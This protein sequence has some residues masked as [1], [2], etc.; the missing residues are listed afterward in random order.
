MKNINQRDFIWVLPLSIGLGAVLSYLQSGNWLIGWLGFSLLFL[1]CFSLLTL[2]IRWAGGGKTLA[3]MVA[4]AFAL[5]FVGGVA[6]YLALPINGFNDADD[7]AGFVYTDAHRRDDQAWELA[8]F[9]STGDC[10]SK[11]RW[12]AVG[13]HSV[14]WAWYFGN[15]ACLA[16]RGFSD[17]SPFCR[18]DIFHQGT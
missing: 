3:W 9:W 6:T 8:K 4:L 15:V 2:S 12:P 10:P 11:V 1:L 13:L 7:K 5:R 16:C 14:A 17:A 18:V